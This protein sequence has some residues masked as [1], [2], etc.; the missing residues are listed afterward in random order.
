MCKQ[1]N[2][3]MMDWVFTLTNCG[4][5]NRKKALGDKL[6]FIRVDLSEVK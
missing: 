4:W 1:A 3:E 5:A 2:I 6:Y